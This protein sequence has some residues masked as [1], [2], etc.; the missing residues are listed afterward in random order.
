MDL[1]QDHDLTLETLV[2]RL[3]Q[4]KLSTQPCES[5]RRYVTHGLEF[6]CWVDVWADQKLIEFSTYVD[7]RATGAE[8]S[9]NCERLNRQVILPCFFPTEDRLCAKYVMTFAGAVIADHV[10][11]ML[12]RF[13]G[14]FRYGVGLVSDSDPF[15]LLGPRTLNS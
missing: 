1:I 14:A 2:R 9:D 6:P 13:A 4:H 7:L 10:V 12:Q 8:L 5:G 3:E 11:Q 15:E